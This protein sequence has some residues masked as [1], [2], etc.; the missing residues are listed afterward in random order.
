MGCGNGGGHREIFWEI[1]SRGVGNSGPEAD[2]GQTKYKIGD[3]REND[4]IVRSEEGGEH[5]RYA[6]LSETISMVVPDF[7]IGPQGWLV[8]FSTMH[9]T[10]TQG[11]KGNIGPFFSPKLASCI[12]RRDKRSVHD[13]KKSKK[14][15]VKR[16]FF[17][18]TFKDFSENGWI[19]VIF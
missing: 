5:R 14:I 10:E 15:H 12:L 1:G 2:F 19:C 11:F 3:R 17:L 9:H 6:F 8:Q 13:F 7:G 4:H 18:P 16:L